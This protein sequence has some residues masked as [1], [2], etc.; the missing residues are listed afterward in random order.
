[1]I[2]TISGDSGTG[3]TTLARKLSSTLELPYFYAGSIFR[4][5]ADERKI[6]LLDFIDQPGYDMSIDRQV[7]AEMITIM[8]TESRAIVEG[9]LSGYL[10]WRHKIPSF[11]ILLTASPTI[12]AQR[13]AHREQQPL[14]LALAE[15]TERDRLDWQRYK[16]IYGIEKQTSHQ[17][18]QL[19][20][21]TDTM[22]I[23]AV[24]QAC[25]QAIQQITDTTR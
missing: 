7:D 8:S 14:E 19:I 5:I 15:V 3:T 11:R 1:M 6:R 2:I 13:I 23:D 18:Y 22:D 17:W 16:V 4:S 25:F 20:L 21:D 24:Y 12:Q 9:R 10:A